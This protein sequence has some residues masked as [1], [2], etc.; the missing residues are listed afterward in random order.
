MRATLPVL[1]LSLAVNVALA[2]LV[3]SPRTPAGSSPVAAAPPSPAGTG[4]AASVTSTP[5]TPASGAIDANSPDRDYV[6][7]LRAA[8]MPPDLVRMLTMMRVAERYRD[9]RKALQPAQPDEYW[10]AN[11]GN[12]W[13]AM[14]PEV[15]AKMRELNREMEAEVRALVGDD[16][17]ALGPY[18]RR[19]YDQLAGI[20][21]PDK[22]RQIDAIKQDYDELAAQ[23]REQSKGLVLKAD[24]E[25]LRLVERERRRDL[26][27]LL[28]P[29]ELL[30]LDL[31]TSSTAGALRNRLAFFAPTEEEFRALGRLQLEF[32]Q[33][34]GATDLSGEEQD[35]RR[36][37]EKDL[38]AKIQAT[39]SPG[40][41]NDYL[42]A[43]DGMF[44]ETRNFTNAYDLDPSVAK[45]IVQLKQRTWKRIDELGFLG[46][47]QRNAALRGLEQEVDNYLTAW[48]GAETLAKYKR[49]GAGWL[50]RLQPAPAPPP[51]P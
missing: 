39:L 12:T 9:R 34:F 7:R 42:V 50:R 28:T 17:E 14:T 27:A 23:V 11:H 41:Y 13:A 18:E 15:R 22:I 32:F 2:A 4:V 31:R 21:S 6:A 38:L 20:L 40:R 43:T 48:L 16:P 51:R 35:R 45:S 29:E 8:G 30:E 49:S 25:L 33:Q 24:R 3:F 10:R 44:S 46:P 19:T 36:A 47:D 26:E 1:L 5:T 37:G